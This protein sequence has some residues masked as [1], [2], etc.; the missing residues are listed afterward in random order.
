MIHYRV[1]NVNVEHC[2]PLT[3]QANLVCL[4]AALIFSEGYYCAHIFYYI[5]KHLN[6]IGVLSFFRICSH[7][8]SLIFLSIRSEIGVMILVTLEK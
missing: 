8:F 6:F 2:V 1:S 3:E 5:A 4:I 7:F